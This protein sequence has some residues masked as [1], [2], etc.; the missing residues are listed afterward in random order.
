[1][2]ARTGNPVGKPPRVPPDSWSLRTA[3]AQ[4]IPEFI[5]WKQLRQQLGLSIRDV[6]ALTNVS[7]NLVHKWENGLAYPG[8]E[9]HRRLLHTL[10]PAR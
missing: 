3:Q 9:A 10:E 4:G 7:R 2:P 8:E 5:L 6:A 1:M